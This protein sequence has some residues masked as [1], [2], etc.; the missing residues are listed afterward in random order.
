MFSPDGHQSV[1]PSP[2][3]ESW[4]QEVLEILGVGV[5]SGHVRALHVLR[6]VRFGG[7][8]SVIVTLDSPAAADD[9]YETAFLHGKEVSCKRAGPKFTGTRPCRLPRCGW[10]A[11]DW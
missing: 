3:W 9:W 4:F 7:R 6:D 10:Q 8:V 5:A 1:A 2:S 11:S